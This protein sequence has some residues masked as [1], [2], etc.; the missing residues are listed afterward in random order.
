[1]FVLFKR[2]VA[3]RAI[4]GGTAENTLLF[5]Q[6]TVFMLLMWTVAARPKAT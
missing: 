1:M 4:A 5:I 3:A 6:T 2:A